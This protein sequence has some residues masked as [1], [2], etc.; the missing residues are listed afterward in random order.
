VPRA[1]AIDRDVARHRSGS[2][3]FLP[4]DIVVRTPHGDADV[5]IASH[6]PTTTLGD[7]VAAVT[8]QAVPRLVVVD[9][10]AVDA[11][12]PLDDADLLVGSVVASAAPTPP[13][14][15][16]ADV[17]LVQVAG[18]GA[19]RMRRLEPGRYRIGPGRRSSANELDVA[20]VERCTFELVV[21]ATGTMSEVSVV[22]EASDVTIDGEHLDS[23]RPW[24]T[25]TLTVGSRAFQLDN[26]APSDALWPHRR[27]EPD[28]TL[29][30]SRPPRRV[31]ASPRRPVVDAVR[32]ATDAAPTLW[33]RRPDHPDAFVLPIGVRTDGSG[34]FDFDLGSERA[35]AIAGSERFRDALAR[36]LL[37][38]A[39]TLHGPADLD[40]V[41]LTG[42]DRLAHWD[43][44]KWLA[45]LRVD[46][47][48]A[49]WS[50]RHDVTRW[51]ESVDAATV[52]ATAS[53][54]PSRLTVVIIDDPGLWNRP[55]SPIRSVVSNPPAGLRLIALCDDETL[56]PA[57]CT[58]VISET[59]DD[60]ARVHSF[61]RA[62]D[63]LL[64]RA[65]LTEADVAVRV[66]RALAP[67]TDVELPPPSAPTTGDDDGV[68]L[69]ELVGATAIDEIL[70][71][72][73]TDDDR[74][75][76]AI[77][78]RGDERVDVPIADDVTVVLG[79]S[80]GDAFDVAA[81]ALLG[82]CVDR[83]PDALWIA[84]MVLEHSPRA[85]LLWRLPHAT[86]RH[87]FDATIDPR[88]LLARLRAVLDGAPARV[89]LV[90]DMAGAS[91]TWPDAT[92]LTALAEGVR[93]I[94]GLAMVVVTDR[95]D[96]ANLLGDTVIRV[97]RRYDV[98]GIER[99]VAIVVAPDGSIAQPFTPLQPTTS[100]V[101]GLVMRP[102][103]VGRALTPLERR[104][105]QDAAQTSN[106]PDPAL[107][108]VV[109]VLRDAASQAGRDDPP[110]TPGGRTVVPPPIPTR[111]ALDELFDGSPG[112]GVPLGLVD[113]PGSASL[114]I[115]WWEPGS[116]SMLVFGSR[117]SGMEQVLATILL[118]VIDRF[119]ALDVRLV[120]IEPSAAR[121][122]ALGGIDR[123]MRVVAPDR[124]DEVSAALDEIAAELERCASTSTSTSTSAGTGGP[125][126]VVL[127]GDLVDLRRRYA[128]QS[129]GDR[130]DE[131]LARAAVADSGVDVVAAASEL[132][133][134]GPFTAAAASV[135]VGASSDLEELAA[136]GIDRPS[137]LDGI[138]GRCRSFPGGDLVQI[139]M[140]ST[141]I[142]DLL[143]RRS[144]GGPT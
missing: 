140:S 51:A 102:F 95:P 17:E 14:V 57:V 41:V 37:V 117:R 143:A 115:R 122:R 131:V 55:D 23:A 96:V 135:L 49:I 94:A 104:I 34:A 124:S 116:G 27:P 137:D 11:S 130:I 65:A 111:V 127:I 3:V 33:E 114:R 35:V 56:A 19:G 105:E 45:H 6:A 98:P 62:G 9:G 86:D 63:E 141:T 99:R 78:R 1:L 28:G 144:I 73:A 43:W 7:V 75:T 20:P 29:P 138:I 88:R 15:S 83:P 76:T 52:T 123:S 132:E 82:Q 40:L 2:V 66:A 128:G 89:V 110:T 24:H 107:G 133:G 42:Q 106:A 119:T 70:T 13:G 21:E 44:A 58:S 59:G 85:E 71:R 139:A 12:T 64:V 54:R 8:G 126:M 100:A 50:S 103:V 16:D 91:T 61:A 79:S 10:R 53:A 80:M 93:T 77:G 25:G 38:E 112:D 18:H 90:A 32:A 60:L 109:A 67:L 39:V 26:P 92:W 47:R 46:G 5:S 120:A 72:W 108:T 30:F 121:R 125:Q 74:T 48:P 118:G 22:P 31:S 69:H 129:V 81:T 4:M 84:P 142:E 113:D 136:L 101:G 134:A 87:E 97:D 68:E 36:S